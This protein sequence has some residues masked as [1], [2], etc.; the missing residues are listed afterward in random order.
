MGKEEM[1]EGKRDGWG[2]GM[3]EGWMDGGGMDG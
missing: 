3:E 1:D 2:K